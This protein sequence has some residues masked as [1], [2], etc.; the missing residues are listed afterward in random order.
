MTNL[1]K[2]LTDLFSKKVFEVSVKT[3]QKNN[4]IFIEKNKCVVHIKSKPENNKANDEIET[5]ISKIS[6]VSAKIIRGKT[7]KKKIIKL[8]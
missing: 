7:S 5:Y 3:S 4:N 2:E 1:S 6:G 8:S